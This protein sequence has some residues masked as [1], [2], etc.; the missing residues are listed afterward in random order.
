MHESIWFGFLKM[1]ILC[2]QIL[3]Q[4]CHALLSLEL[5]RTLEVMGINCEILNIQ[6]H[7]CQLTVAA[8]FGLIRSAGCLKIQFRAGYGARPGG[9]CIKSRYL[10]EAQSC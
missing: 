5:S 3:N 10:L 6:Y 4:S 8:Y 9:H 1:T 2:E 7:H